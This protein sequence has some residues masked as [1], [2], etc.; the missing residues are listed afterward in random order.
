MIDT[1]QD[2]DLVK[3]DLQR[4]EDLAAERQPWEAT[5]QEIDER[6]PDGAGGF[7]TTAPGQI[8]LTFTSA[9]VGNGAARDAGTLAGQDGGLAVRVQ[10][11]D[12][13]DGLTGPLSRYDDEGTLFGA[14]DGSTFDIRDLVSG[15]QRGDQFRLAYLGT[16]GDDSL[17]LPGL[18]PGSS[19]GDLAT[20]INA[21][22]GND[23]VTTG[24]GKAGPMT[25]AS[26]TAIAP[27]VT[28][29]AVTPDELPGSGASRVRV[30]ARINTRMAAA[31]T[32][33]DS[34]ST[35]LP[36][37]LTAMA[38]MSQTATRAMDAISGI[39]AV[40]TT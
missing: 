28:A 6:F 15:V 17:S 39:R 31:S 22:Q 38:G 37:R 11:E 5:F 18:V 1:L 32:T 20:Y 7:V 35:L 21:G 14:E 19:D 9:E 30:S 34:T 25:S 26:T 12:G 40:T 33:N 24:A 23:T 16:S 13:A 8:R 27:L 10:A 29:T 2:S 36:P 3:A 4:Q